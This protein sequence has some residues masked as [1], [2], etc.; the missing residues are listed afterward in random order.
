M[1]R[2]LDGRSS[3]VSGVSF[4]TCSC[5]IRLTERGIRGVSGRFAHACARF[6]AFCRAVVFFFVL[7]VLPRAITVLLIVKLQFPRQILF[8][9]VAFSDMTQMIDTA[10]VTG[11]RDVHFNTLDEAIADA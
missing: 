6:C 2:S 9:S 11:R 3:P 7:L 1:P 10:K 5:E 8:R 4:G